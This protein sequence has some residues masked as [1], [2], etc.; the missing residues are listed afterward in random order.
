LDLDNVRIVFQRD[1]VFGVTHPIYSAVQESGTRH[2]PIYT[3]QAAAEEFVAR[4]NALGGRDLLVAKPPDAAGLL[5]LL[6]RAK[7]DGVERY[8]LDAMPGARVTLWLL[9][10][11]IDDVREVVSGG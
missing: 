1:P 10:D 3:T 5:E 9:Q 6:T 7:A 2:L 8:T 11:A 4:A